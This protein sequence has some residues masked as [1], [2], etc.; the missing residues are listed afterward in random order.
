MRF[1]IDTPQPTPRFT[2]DARAVRPAP[3]GNERTSGLPESGCGNGSAAVSRMHRSTGATLS[4]TCPVINLSPVR[5]AFFSRISTGSNPQAAASLSI[6]DSWAKQACTTPKPRIAPQGGLL[7]RTA[8]PSTV[9]I[10]HLYGPC[11][12]VTALISTADEVEA[13]APP[14]STTRASTRR[15][16]PSRSA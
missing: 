11:M 5:M 13:Y 15:K 10:S 8:K 6:C 9:A 7:L 14:S 1:L 2:L 3:P 4:I 16:V 12:W